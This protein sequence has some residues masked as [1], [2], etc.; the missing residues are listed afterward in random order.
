V[1]IYD[2]RVVQPLDPSMV[3]DL[4]THDV[5]VSIEDGLRVGGAGAGVRDAL[6]ERD[7]DCRVRVLGVPVEYVPHGHPHG[8]P[9]DLHAG[10]GLNAAGIAS[11]VRELL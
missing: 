1:T 7:A 4:A 11:S 3:D 8:H 2:P 5:V 9:D 6:G 10:F